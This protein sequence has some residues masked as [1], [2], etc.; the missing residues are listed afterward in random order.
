MASMLSTTPER[1]FC[2]ALGTPPTPPPVE[3][4]DR[5]PTI[6]TPVEQRGATVEAVEI[7]VC[8][9]KES[10]LT[11]LQ[12]HEIWKG[13]SIIEFPLFTSS[14]EPLQSLQPFCPFFSSDRDIYKIDR[15][16]RI[17]KLRLREEFSTILPVLVTL[18]Y[19]S[20]LEQKSDT[21]T[22]CGCCWLLYWCFWVVGCWNFCC[23]CWILGCWA[24]KSCCLGCCCCCCCCWGGWNDG[25]CASVWKGVTA[26]LELLRYWWFTGL[27]KLVPDRRK[28]C[29]CWPA[30]A[31]QFADKL[32]LAPELLTK[33]LTTGL[34]LS[35]LLKFEQRDAAGESWKNYDYYIFLKRV[36]S[37]SSE[38]WTPTVNRELGLS[39]ACRKMNPLAK[40][41]RGFCSTM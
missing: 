4:L 23:C 25:V 27:S 30:F 18:K 5:L 29:C 31:P 15:R 12:R 20:I 14:R 40:D 41:W 2:S 33:L 17:I 39:P 32:T 8:W 7:V 16:R 11:I 36:E 13:E 26:M 10:M 22:W 35:L 28:S 1:L 3:K 9:R 21:L 34:L 19:P 38:N 6:V 24:P 37:L